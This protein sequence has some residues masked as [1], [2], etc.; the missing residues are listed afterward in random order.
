MN[1]VDF[2]QLCLFVA[3]A[4]LAWRLLSDGSKLIL[5]PSRP[6]ALKLLLRHQQCLRW[7]EAREISEVMGDEFKTLGS[8]KALFDGF[9]IFRI[10]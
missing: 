2:V 7:K 10:N 5:I 1:Q 9:N 3:N 8:M 4:P 6:P